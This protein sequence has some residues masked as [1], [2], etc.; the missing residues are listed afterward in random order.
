LFEF[1]SLEA[2]HATLEE[3]AK[4]E[5]PLVTQLPRRSGQKEARYM[6]LL[7]GEVNAEEWEEAGEPVKMTGSRLEERVQALEAE[8]AE[9]KLKLGDLLK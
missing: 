1:G 8:L 7:S 4:K 9:I 3:L 6:H 2:V 5:F